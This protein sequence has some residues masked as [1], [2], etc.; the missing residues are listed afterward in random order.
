MQQLD[1]GSD[2]AWRNFLPGAAQE[3]DKALIVE[4]FVGKKLMGAKSEV[5]GRPVYEDREFVKIMIKGQDKQIVIEEVKPAH[6]AKYPIAYLQFQQSKPMPLIGT[7]IEMLPGVGPSMAHHLKGIN[8]R[9]VEDVAN[10]SDENVLQAMGPGARD[11][12][13]RAKAFV[14]HTSEKTAAL[15]AELAEQKA[16]N[17]R[18]RGTIEN[19]ESRLAQVES[20]PPRTR[21]RP[22]KKEA[23]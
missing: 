7:P 2:D 21:R 23:N 13:K 3:D 1:V 16:E 10:I 8:L 18:L 17:Q 14:G 4:F 15:E 20:R 6:K 22:S 5:L 11:L 19:F 12:V 9:S